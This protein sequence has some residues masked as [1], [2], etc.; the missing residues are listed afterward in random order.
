MGWVETIQRDSG[1]RYRGVAWDA[2]AGRRCRPEGSKTSKTFDTF[3]AA[4]AWWR[5]REPRADETYARVAD[6]NV[7]RQRKRS[8][9]GD[10][11]DL[12]LAALEG[13]GQLAAHG[14]QP[15]A[16]MGRRGL[17]WRSLI[18]L[19]EQTSGNNKPLLAEH[20]TSP[21]GPVGGG[22]DAGRQSVGSI[23][24]VPVWLSSQLSTTETQGT[25][26]TSSAYV[27][28]AAQIVAVMR[29]DLLVPYPEAVV[30][31]SGILP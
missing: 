20:A 8:T 23:Y 13:Q 10:Y 9:F 19:K 21:A 27:Y 15:R 18:K 12:W 31:I 29:A 5:S 3:E 16:G 25:A 26:T 14:R 28:D 22:A 17:P 2:Q 30:R 24:G 1:L 7:K 4:D 6:I 11:A